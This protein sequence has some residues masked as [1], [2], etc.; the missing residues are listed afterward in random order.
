MLAPSGGLAANKAKYAQYGGNASTVGGQLLG[1]AG[2]IAQTYGTPSAA[3]AH[4]QSAHW[5]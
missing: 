2:Y 1:M 4:E 3:W 5:Y